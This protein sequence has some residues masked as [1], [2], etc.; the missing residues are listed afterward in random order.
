M[1]WI[2][3]LAGAVLW[4]LCTLIFYFIWQEDEDKALTAS[5]GLVGGVLL[6]VIKLTNICKSWWRRA[7]FKAALV[8][9]DGKL[10][11]CESRDADFYVMAV[12][13]EE[14][15]ALYNWARHLRDKYT[16][17]DGWRDR[18]CR[19]GVISLIYTPIKVLKAEGAYRLPRLSKEDR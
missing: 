13:D 18:D 17:S 3:L 14:N 12:A 11:Y 5:S 16:V 2:G 7:H 6:L 19:M 8:D 9:K 15:K 1:F 4:Q 10:C